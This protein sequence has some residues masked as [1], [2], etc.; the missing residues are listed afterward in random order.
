[1]LLLDSYSYYISTKS[2]SMVYVGPDGIVGCL[3]HNIEIFSAWTDCDDVDD[4]GISDDVALGLSVDPE[5]VRTCISRSWTTVKICILACCIMVGGSF[6]TV[7]AILFMNKSTSSSSFLLLVSC[8]SIFVRW[9]DC[10]SKLCN[11]LFFAD[12]VLGTVF[13]DRTESDEWLELSRPNFILFWVLSV[14]WGVVG[15]DSIIS[16]EISDSLMLSKSKSYEFWISSFWLLLSTEV[17]KSWDSLFW[18]FSSWLI[19]FWMRLEILKN[20]S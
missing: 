8:D 3:K 10:S 6:L 16:V 5:D 19:T 2:Y 4:S 20:L 17:G 15:W 7:T 12:W 1:M 14:N 9:I 13:C 11:N 18:L